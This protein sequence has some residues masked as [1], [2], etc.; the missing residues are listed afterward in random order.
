[1]NAKAAT[2]IWWIISLIVLALLVMIILGGKYYG[3]EGL[4]NGVKN[5][6]ETL[7]NYT[8]NM[9]I[10]LKELNSSTTFLPEGAQQEAK[11][12]PRVLKMMAKP[13][14]KNCFS[15]VDGGFST[16]LSSEEATSPEF[17]FE[18]VGNKTKVTIFSQKSVIHSN[19]DV[20]GM[21]PCVIAGP[22]NV[23][24][25]FFK[26]F[27]VRD[28]RYMMEDGKMYLSESP[29]A[30]GGYKQEIKYYTPVSTIDIYYN[31]E[32]KNGNVIRVPELGADTVNGKQNLESNGVLFKGSNG[33]I[34]FFPT[35]WVVNGD[36]DGID[37]DFFEVG[38]VESLRY[39]IDHRE[40]NLCTEG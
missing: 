5:A 27:I 31:Q 12:L 33:E 36:E 29:L 35:N 37:N 13:H 10:G 40:V 15:F 7:W 3:E 1:M 38:R 2:Q 4:F 16:D 11:A 30:D 26:F 25:N 23:A 21:V 9:S 19:F 22:N 6:A 32:G 28:D 24:E 8:P 14:N 20:P 39:K 34:C 18:I 17:L